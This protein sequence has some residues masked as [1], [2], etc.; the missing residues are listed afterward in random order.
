MT[1]MIM[2][3]RPSSCACCHLCY[4]PSPA[5]EEA[6]IRCA[7]GFVYRGRVNACLNVSRALGDAQVRAPRLPHLSMHAPGMR[8]PS[9][10][11]YHELGAWVLDSA[12]GS[13]R[14]PVSHDKH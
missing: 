10:Y 13:V 2:Y 11:P 1:M 9:L 7:G 4:L 5:Q 6:R 12:T 8:I 3:S 14:H